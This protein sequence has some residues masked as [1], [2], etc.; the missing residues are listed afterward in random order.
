[1]YTHIYE[2]VDEGS[3]ESD[4]RVRDFP[5]VLAHRVHATHKDHGSVGRTERIEAF[6]E[7]DRPC[8][9][10]RRTTVRVKLAECRSQTRN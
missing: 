10:V 2:R 1:M 7:Y 8:V 9:T 4:A 5:L 3:V 6:D